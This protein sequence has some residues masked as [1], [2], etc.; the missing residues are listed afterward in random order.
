MEK[1]FSKFL[2]IFL[3]IYF[4]FFSFYN[5]NWG[6]PFYFHPDERNIASSIS[7]LNYTS[8]LNPN[9]FAYGQ[10]PIYTIYLVSLISNFISRFSINPSVTFEQAIITGRLIS[11]LISIALVYLIYKT[12][13]ELKSKTAGIFAFILAATS[14]AF[15][16]FNHFT[17][18]EIWLCYFYLLTTF[19]L[20][21]FIKTKKYLFFAAASA[22]FGILCGLKLSSLAFGII[23]IYSIIIRLIEIKKITPGLIEFFKLTAIFIFS[24]AVFYIL[25]SPFNFLDLRQFINSMNY[26]TGV[27]VG[28]MKVFYTGTFENQIPVIFQVQKILPFLIN[29]LLTIISIPAAIYTFY[30]SVKKRNYQFGLFVFAFIILFVLPSFLYVKWTRYI[31]PAIPFLYILTSIFLTD[32]ANNKFVVK[33]IPKIKSLLIILFATSGIIFS[34]SFLKTVRFDQDSRIRA[35]NFA[36]IVVPDNSKILSEVYDLGIV[37]FND[38]Y[39][40][41]SLFNFYDLDNGVSQIQLLPDALS[42]SEYIILPS[43]RV[44]ESRISHKTSFP[45]GNNFYSKLFSENSQFKKIYE[46][47][48]DIFCKITYMGDPVFNSELTASVFDRPTVFIFKKDK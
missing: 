13:I 15:L 31:V 30:I 32:L 27:A 28:T 38:R 34:L 24:S 12:T 41:I 46:T 19:L 4:I 14:T 35:L 5:L 36:K 29:P 26:E 7:Q 23:P 48:C 18:F 11:A 25:T 17:T 39:H 10:L 37:P 44:Y 8:N 21:R 33:N 47:P 42:E 9:F 16:Q 2:F 45:N 22:C 3:T 43:P 1:T 20:A 6:A 40:N